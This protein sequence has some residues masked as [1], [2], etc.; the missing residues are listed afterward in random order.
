MSA[1]FFSVH[2]LY[3]AR[4]KREPL[5]DG[6][7]WRR[8]VVLEEWMLYS[9]TFTLPCLCLVFNAILN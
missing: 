3:Y 1:A 4:Q 6:A 9:K 5:L 2:V 7:G 8:E